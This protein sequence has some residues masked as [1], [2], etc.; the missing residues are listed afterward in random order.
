MTFRGFISVDIEATSDIRTFIHDVRETG[1][2]LNMVN[3]EKIHI[4]V[5]FLGD[6]EEDTVVDINDKVRTIV[7]D[8]TPFKLKLK[9]AGA[10]PKLDYMKV[11]WIG[12]EKTAELSDIAH[13]IE[14]VLVP[15]GFT[16]EKRSFSPH[17]T[18][19]RVKG[20]RNKNRLKAVL[21]DYAAHDFGGQRVTKLKLKKSVLKGEGPEYTT[22]EKYYLG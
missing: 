19:A 3:P 10:F 18:I 16:R 2:S 21:N 11:V 4:T 6:T 9:G 8:H 7:R 15:L 17:I 1:A 20:G 12:V 13:R 22:L 5:K 14:E